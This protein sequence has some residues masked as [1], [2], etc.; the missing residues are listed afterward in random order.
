MD[1]HLRPLNF[2]VDDLTILTAG[3]LVLLSFRENNGIRMHQVYKRFMSLRDLARVQHKPESDFVLSP[4]DFNLEDLESLN[5]A[6]LAL[7]V[8]G[9]NFNDTGDEHNLSFITIKRRAERIFLKRRETHSIPAPSP[10][11]SHLLQSS[12]PY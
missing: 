3:E 12:L 7:L 5:S 11:H 8:A 1:F 6:S 10:P 2:P 4:L 9:L